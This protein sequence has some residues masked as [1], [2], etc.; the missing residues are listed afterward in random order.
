[1]MIMAMLMLLMTSLVRVS[2]PCL[3]A[4]TVNSRKLEHQYPKSLIQKRREIQHQSS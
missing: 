4:V 1:M 2:T 3:E